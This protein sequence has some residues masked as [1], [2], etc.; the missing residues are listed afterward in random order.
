MSGVGANIV[1][2]LIVSG[3]QLLLVP[4]LANA[5]GL[6]LYGL[7]VMMFTAPSFLAMGDFGFAQAAGTKMT[8]AVARGEHEE[9]VNIFQSAWVAILTSSAGLVALAALLVWLL[10]ESLLQ[11]GAG[12]AAGDI[13]STLFLLILYGIAA[14]QGS[15]FFAGFRCAGLFAV[16]A[17]WNA[18]IILVESSAVIA[19]VWLGGAGPLTA[20]AA[21]LGGR[22]VGLA[23]QFLLLR[24]RVPWLRVGLTRARWE[25]TRRLFAPAGAVML[26]PIAQALSLQGTALALGAVA[27][28]A[29]VPAFTA[30]RTLSRVGM[31]MCWLLNTPLMPEFTAAS[32]R[33][34]RGAMATMVL[35]TLAMTV[36]LVLPY[37]G[38]FALLG[39]E[40]ILLWTGGAIHAPEPLLLAMAGSMVFGGFWYPVSNLI[41]ALNRHASY[42]FYYVLFAALSLPATYLLAERFGATGAGLAMMTMDAAMLVLIVLIARRL[43]VSGDELRRAV[44][45]ARKRLA[46]LFTRKVAKT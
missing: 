14:I 22:L 11:G 27:G 33:K 26:V 9:A 18:L 5:W 42:T 38:I 7:W 19:V 2:K 32:A 43:L 28:E 10:P 6:H 35:A 24:Q 44:P 13:R 31:Q 30:A 8:M 12:M 36:L 25:E 1:D 34:D 40:A 45:L 41:L 3:T 39:Q 20:A 23:G 21:F 16:G 46:E 4:V 37:A 29:A 17:F 15:I